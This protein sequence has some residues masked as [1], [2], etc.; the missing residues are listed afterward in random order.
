MHTEKSAFER[1]T[2]Y[3]SSREKVTQVVKVNPT[4]FGCKRFAYEIEK[5]YH[6]IL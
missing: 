6:M 3:Q 4:S 5:I 1:T 2:S